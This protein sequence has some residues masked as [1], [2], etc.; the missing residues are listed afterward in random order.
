MR[1]ET[2]LHMGCDLVVSLAAVKIS[3]V[4][5][6]DQMYAGRKMSGTVQEQRDYFKEYRRLIIEG[7]TNESSNRAIDL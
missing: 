4:T 2:F 5:M 1:R 7:K 3:G 6:L